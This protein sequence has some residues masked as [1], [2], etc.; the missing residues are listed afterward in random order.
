[1]SDYVDRCPHC[2]VDL[3]DDGTRVYCWRC[4]WEVRD[5]D[6]PRRYSDVSD[7][8]RYRETGAWQ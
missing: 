3:D 6:E 7:A 2:D 8:I 1:M 5:R 4:D